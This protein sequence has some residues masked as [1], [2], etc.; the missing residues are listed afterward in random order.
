MASSA[1]NDAAVMG[2]GALWLCLLSQLCST[3]AGLYPASVSLGGCGG[4]CSNSNCKDVPVEIVK[5]KRAQAF[6]QVSSP[7]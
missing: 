4:E 3:K 2:G 7:S 5:H 6:R 1:P